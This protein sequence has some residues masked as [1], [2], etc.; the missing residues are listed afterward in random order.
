MKRVLTLAA[1][2]L[3]LGL[4]LCG[5][6][7]PGGPAPDFTLPSQDGSMIGLSAYKG[8]YIV[9]EWFNSG[10]PFVKKHYEPGNMQ[11]LQA[12]YTAKG[13]I[14]L[15]INSSAK[16]KEGYTTPKEAGEIRMKWKSPSTAVLLDSAGK[17]GKLY[18]AKT[19]PHIF[20]ISPEGR[21]IYQGAIDDK[22]SADSADIASSKNYVAAA[23]D[24]AL[25]GQAVAEAST[26]PYGCSVK[27]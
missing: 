21:V 4:G 19:T 18:G 6:I 7:E 25:A 12:T 9:L 2:W 22:A 15:S 8:K 13:V 16:G 11:K 17:V 10:C 26:K 20:I 1:V 14:W 27:Y 3:G 23:L 24:A 5:A